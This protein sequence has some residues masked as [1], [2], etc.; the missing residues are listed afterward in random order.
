MRYVFS[1]YATGGYRALR[2]ALCA[3]LIGIVIDAYLVSL[4]MFMWPLSAMFAYAASDFTPM[5]VPVAL[6]LHVMYKRE[7]VIRRSI[8]VK[9]LA[10]AIVRQLEPVQQKKTRVIDAEYTVVE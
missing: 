3:F 7:A 4:F 5:G 8:C 9:G 1:I 10:Y 6:T 2:K